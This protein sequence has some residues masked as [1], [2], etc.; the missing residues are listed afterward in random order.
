[1]SS[2]KA[3]RIIQSNIESSSESKYEIP[4]EKCVVGMFMVGFEIHT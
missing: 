1:M 2:V 4:C 3:F